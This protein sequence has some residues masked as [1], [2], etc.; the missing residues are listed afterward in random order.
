MRTW[1]ERRWERVNEENEAKKKKRKE[2]RRRG[3][4]SGR[5]STEDTRQDKLRRSREE[6]LEWKTRER[7]EIHA[8]YNKSYPYHEGSGAPNNV[9]VLGLWPCGM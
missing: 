3:K 5:R 2:R 1:R 4:K 7:E 9:D 8:S 6:L